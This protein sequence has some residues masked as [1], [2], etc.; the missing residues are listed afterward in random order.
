MANQGPLKAPRPAPRPVKKPRERELY[1]TVPPMAEG[2]EKVRAE[3]KNNIQ[4]ATVLELT[5]E[6]TLKSGEEL[7]GKL[8]EHVPENFVIESG[9]AEK[10]MDLKADFNGEVVHGMTLPGQKR[11]SGLYP[12]NKDGLV[13]YS[14]PSNNRLT[15]YLTHAPGWDPEDAL[16]S[17]AAA[18]TAGDELIGG[19]EELWQKKG[20]TDSDVIGKVFKSASET[21]GPIREE[22][23][24]PDQQIEMLGARVS[25]H[26]DQMNWRL[27][28][29]NNGNNHCLVI[30]QNGRFERFRGGAQSKSG[31]ALE[32]PAMD[33]DS[34]IGP[35]E[36]VLIVTDAMVQAMGGED[37]LVNMFFNGLKSRNQ[38]IKDTC[39]YLMNAI[40]SK[41]KN[42][43]AV[44]TSVSLIAFRVPELPAT[45]KV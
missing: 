7:M 4:R 13:I 42:G 30:S 10:R 35:G 33:V 37:K 1:T 8:V 34:V 36:I 40:D 20:L 32:D 2:A 28:V 12:E 21:V 3:T 31:K 6:D 15:I 41:Q 9:T 23:D 5:A 26:H 16:L 18:V 39:G 22:L 43:D 25:L 29:G 45:P 44:D 24:K 27:T 38:S 14:E 17:N 19:N 11:P